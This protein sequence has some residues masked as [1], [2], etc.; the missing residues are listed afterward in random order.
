MKAS[1]YRK[2]LV[3]VCAAAQELGAD[4][5]NPILSKVLLRASDKASLVRAQSDA[6]GLSVQ[7]RSSSCEQPGDALVDMQAL[8]EAVR[9]MPDDHLSVS[10][11]R[12]TNYLHLRGQD[13]EYEWPI[14][15]RPMDFP[16]FPFFDPENHHLLT[17]AA[18][19]TFFHRVSAC[20]ATK[21]TRWA[22]QGVQLTIHPE[23]I[24]AVATDSRHLAADSTPVQMVGENSPAPVIVPRRAI[25]TL[26]RLL[27]AN[28]EE[29]LKLYA[30]P[31]AV[32]FQ[33]PSFT[34][35]ARTLAGGFPPAGPLLALKQPH[36]V[37]VESRAFLQAL[38]RATPS[39]TAELRAVKV[40]LTPD[41]VRFSSDA[42]GRSYS[43]LACKY[44][45]PPVHF[46]VNPAFP[47]D[48]LSRFP[49]E[50][51]FTIS[52]K[53]EVSPVVFR[54][55]AFPDFVYIITTMADVRQA[56]PSAIEA[57]F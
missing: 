14:H 20:C 44:E 7:V 13:A 30:R 25:D 17:T 23:S 32:I 5:S 8:R 22:L 50:T 42:K 38:S 37:Q 3:D 47:E 51:P 4:A 54:T 19:Y 6:A 35:F 11:D 29:A 9:Q 55:D 45:G 1:F 12:D 48:V 28:P 16:E 2:D 33:S 18:A 24:C 10:L 26:C 43:R 57:G 40:T 36:S 53:D 39:T 56:P 34:F 15:P 49:P 31:N 41:F 46:L 27:K 52:V 21:E